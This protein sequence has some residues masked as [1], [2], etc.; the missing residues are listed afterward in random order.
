MAG[1]RHTK[2]MVIAIFRMQKWTCMVGAATLDSIFNQNP[3]GPTEGGPMFQDFITTA[4][5]ADRPPLPGDWAENLNIHFK[6][7]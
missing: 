5:P 2:C 7:Y 1:L 3:S 4:R 6:I